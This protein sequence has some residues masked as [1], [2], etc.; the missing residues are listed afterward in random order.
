MNSISMYNKM[1]QGLRNACEY[2]GIKY[3]LEEL[4]AALNEA[5]N[6][7]NPKLIMK[8]IQHIDSFWEDTKSKA[9][10]T[11]QNALWLEIMPDTYT[12]TPM[13]TTLTCD[14]LLTVMKKLGDSRIQTFIFKHHPNQLLSNYSLP[15][16]L[17][18]LSAYYND[19]FAMMCYTYTS[20]S[21]DN[22]LNFLNIV[23]IHVI[24]MV[25][26]EKSIAIHSSISLTTIFCKM[27]DYIKLT[28]EINL[29]SS[30]TACG[31][32]RE[33][34]QKLMGK[35]IPPEIYNLCCKYVN[36]KSKLMC[37]ATTVV[38]KT[39][40]N[41]SIEDLYL[42]FDKKLVSEVDIKKY[43]IV[44]LKKRIWS[45]MNSIKTTTEEIKHW[46]N[47]CNAKMHVPG[48]DW[49]DKSDEAYV[50]SLKTHIGAI[51][52]IYG[53]L[54]QRVNKLILLQNYL[55]SLQNVLYEMETWIHKQ[56][57]QK[58]T[59]KYEKMIA[60]LTSRYLKLDWTTFT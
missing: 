33:I 5:Q 2:V 36:Y 40:T 37:I 23:S 4:N 32:I 51:T 3:T 27:R 22:L 13:F 47:N 30:L 17:R 60:N 9:I 56:E 45:H 26:D 31:Y 52:N 34:E 15:D 50:R 12:F 19:S 46:E 48:R 20:D 6:T 11:L 55:K 29:D 8:Y 42:L 38:R 53:K 49:M 18:F 54:E 39:I 57:L 1:L 28:P 16:L 58:Q 59:E 43:V 7:N 41:L 10:R 21:Q 44:E 35:V 25:L 14:D 24:L